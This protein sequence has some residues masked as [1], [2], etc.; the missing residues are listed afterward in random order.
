MTQPAISALI[1]SCEQQN[2][3]SDMDTGFALACLERHPAFLPSVTQ[4]KRIEKHAENRPMVSIM[5]G[6][7][8]VSRVANRTLQGSNSY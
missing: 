1:F 2:Q 7:D 8:E 6:L 3:A 4:Y 5:S